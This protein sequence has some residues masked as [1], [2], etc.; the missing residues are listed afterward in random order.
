MNIQNDR[1][2]IPALETIAGLFEESIFTRIEHNY[3]Y[4]SSLR[5]LTKFS[6]SIYSYTESWVQI[7]EC[8]E[9]GSVYT[10]VSLVLTI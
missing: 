7:R 2:V 1:I 8:D 5:L 6:T 3:K 10:T 4:D 9:I